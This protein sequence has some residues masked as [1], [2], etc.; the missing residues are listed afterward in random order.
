MYTLLFKYNYTQVPANVHASGNVQSSSY[1]GTNCKH[2]HIVVQKVTEIFN[3]P[4]RDTMSRPA[5]SEELAPG[6]C[7]NPGSFSPIV[8]ALNKKNT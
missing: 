4:K 1:K 6:V 7:T 8:S 3:E 2:S 5:M